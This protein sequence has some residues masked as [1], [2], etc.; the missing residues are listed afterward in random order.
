MSC[1]RSGSPYTVV[2]FTDCDDLWG[3]NGDCGQNYIGITSRTVKVRMKE[4]HRALRLNQPQMSKAI[5]EGRKNSYLSYLEPRT[6]QLQSTTTPKMLPATGDETLDNGV[7]M[8]KKEQ[9][10]PNAI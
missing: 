1:L 8:R 6:S 9:D 3:S 4:Y 10:I 2:V 5:E 7:T